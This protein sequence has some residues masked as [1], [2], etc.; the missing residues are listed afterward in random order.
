MNHRL[1]EECPF[2]VLINGAN[3]KELSDLPH[4]LSSPQYFVGDPFTSLYISP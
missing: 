4:I 2:R 1:K 3:D